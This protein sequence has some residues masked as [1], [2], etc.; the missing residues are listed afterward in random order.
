MIGTVNYMASLYNPPH[1]SPRPSRP[2][3]VNIDSHNLQ[4]WR[5]RLQLIRAQLFAGKAARGKGGRSAAALS[6]FVFSSLPE[7]K[8]VF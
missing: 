3:A 8:L 5:W 4:Q 1:I 7:I 6:H 2:L